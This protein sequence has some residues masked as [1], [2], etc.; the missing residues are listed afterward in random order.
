MTE[1]ALP[2]VSAERLEAITRVLA[3]DDSD[4]RACEAIPAG[5]CTDV[6]RN[7]LLNLAN[8]AATKLAEQLASPGLVL[9]WLLAGI[10]APAVLTG[11]LVPVKQAGSL[12]P[13]LA[14]AGRVRAVAERKWVWVAAG[15][16]QALMLTIIGAGAMLLPQEIAGPL[17]LLAFAVFSAASG[18]GS[19]AFQDVVGKTIPQGRRGRLLSNRALIGGA[20]TLLAAL[21]FRALIGEDASV[22]L[23]VPLIALAALLWALGAAA[24][25]AM[26]EAP[27]A[28]E[29][30]RSML[31]EV[32]AGMRLLREVP[33]FRRFLT[34]R[35]LLLG[36]ELATPFFA[37]HASDLY[38]NAAPLLGTYLLAV[39]L[40]NLLAS[41]FWGRWADVSSRAVMAAA[42][43]LAAGAGVLAL[44]LAWLPAGDLTAWVY[45][46]AFLLAG[47]AEGGLRLGRKTYLTDGAPPDERPLYTAFANTAVGVLALGGGLLGLLADLATP[48]AAIVAVSLLAAAGAYLS[49]R[50]PEARDMA[51]EVRGQSDVG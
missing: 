19:L 34:A 10:G 39:G 32:R 23:A 1:S 17:I 46:L 15:L 45:A 8:G 47:M 29:G 6:P 21:A 27:G 37:L 13:Q 30:G 50:L 31:H 22:Q 36:V 5:S 38:G 2:H 51:L 7:T 48:A 26:E 40:A 43:A 9:P 3:G 44:V 24:F 42:G 49:W 16:F 11:L 33:G 20:L 18:A 4:E 12:L 14:V 35:A 28:T 25:A 41:P